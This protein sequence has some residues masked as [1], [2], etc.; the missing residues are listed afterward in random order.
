MRP[1]FSIVAFIF[2]FIVLADGAALADDRVSAA[3]EQRMTKLQRTGKERLAGKATDEQ[4]VNNCKIPRELRG[5]KARPDSCPET[6]NNN[7]ENRKS[8]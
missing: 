4:R 6:R 2:L 8:Q 5:D 7:Q 3:E 1:A